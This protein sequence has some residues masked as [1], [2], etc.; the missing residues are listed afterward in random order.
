MQAEAA[1][2]AFDDAE[3]SLAAVVKT[4]PGFDLLEETYLFLGLTQFKRAEI[5]PAEQA[6]KHFEAAAATFDALLKS[7]PQSKSLAQVLYTRGDCEYHLDRKEDAVRFYSQALAKSPD[8][9]LEPAILYALG[10]TQQELKRWEEAGKTY[11]DFLTVHDKKYG[12]HR[13]AGEIVMQR[14]E[15]FYE[16]RQYQSAA[17]WF[18]AATGWPGFDKADYATMR[19]AVALAQLDKH[20]EAGDIL[21]GIFAKFPASTRFSL[22][23]KAGDRL[24]RGLIRGNKPADAVALVEKL[25]PH[26]EGR[27]EAALL[28][29]DR[30]DA[31]AAIS[32]RR[33]EAVA[34]YRRG[35]QVPQGPGGSPSPRLAGYW[36][37]TL[38]TPRRASAI[39]RCLPR[40]LSDP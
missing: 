7:Y 31:V 5:E 27:E 6:A 16:T 1:L 21:A 11:D 35:P 29:M 12:G 13:L 4:A 9:K 8:E 20:A 39:C 34:L 40:R 19:Q 28:A 36:A 25:L 33:A 17:D 38:V 2:K 30:A 18:A 32:A 37:M 14:A 23:L 26:A 24:A 10:T 22:V 3:Q 15:M